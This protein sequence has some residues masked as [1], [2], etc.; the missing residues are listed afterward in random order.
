MFPQCFRGCAIGVVATI[1][2]GVLRAALTPWLGPAAPL[3]PF[4][5]A[6]A[7]AA[8]IGGI[9]AGLFTTAV[10]GGI[11]LV[12]FIHPLAALAADVTNNIVLLTFFGLEGALIAY[13]T[14]AL[15]ANHNSLALAVAEEQSLRNRA[16][17]ANRLKQQFLSIVSHELRTPLTVVLGSI[18]KIKRSHDPT[19]RQ[20]GEIIE[21]NA[22]A[23]AQTIDNLLYVSEVLAGHRRLELAPIDLNALCLSVMATLH[24]EARRRKIEMTLLPPKEPAIV[25]ADHE[26]L[27][28][29]VLALLSNAIK[30]S[31]PAGIVDLALSV[32]PSQ[33]EV[34]ISDSGIGMTPATLK[35]VFDPFWQADSSTTRSYGGLGLGLTA[36]REVAALHGGVISARSEGPGRGAR[37]TLTLPRARELPHS[38]ELV[39]RSA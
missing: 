35:T 15:R 6:I 30:F 31:E 9:W 19:A 23:Q 24:D 32:A 3:L 27:R 13:L 36:A 1:A 38:T 37:V 20:A 28:Q 16:E 22:K 12:L 25:Q 39:A 33:V 11:G 21:R 8:W 5:P 14:S 26:P 4:P 29:T 2:V 34:V 7:L 10:A 18:W 17:S